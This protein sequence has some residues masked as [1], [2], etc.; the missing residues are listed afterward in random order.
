MTQQPSYDTDA[1]D[2]ATTHVAVPPTYTL[3]DARRVTRD[4]RPV[5]HFRH[6]RDDNR[7]AGLGGE[8]VSFVVDAETSRLLG[9]TRMEVQHADGDLPDRETARTV[10]EGFLKD[11]APD[12]HGSLDIL[13]IEPHDETITAD[14]HDVVVTGVKVKCRDPSGTYAWVI[15][16]PGTE[17]ITFERD[18]IWNDDMSRRET[19]KWLHDDWLAANTES[20][21]FE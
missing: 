18:V 21:G 4:N 20:P 14:G 13:W 3:V 12:L 9:M 6:E 1:L 17:V 10:A 11:T 7:N 16:G 5:W 8:H 19:E 15:V 2:T